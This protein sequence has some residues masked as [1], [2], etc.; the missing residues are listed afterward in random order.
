MS[1]TSA[2][3]QGLRAAGLRS[4]CW[5][6]SARLLY[7]RG[8]AGSSHAGGGPLLHRR[9]VA[10]AVAGSSHGGGS[11][12][13]GAAS[14]GDAAQ[15]ALLAEVSAIPPDRI[16]NFCIISHVDHG[17]STL[18]DRLM[19]M[20]GAVPPGGQQQMLDS[21]EVERTRGITIK[22]QT[23]SLLHREPSS[24]EAFLLNLIDTPG[25]V[26]FSYEVSR[27]IA[28][29]QGALLLVDATK[30]VQA[31]TV[32]N[33][34]LAFEQELAIT[35]VVNKIDLPHA[36]VDAVLG[37]IRDAFDLSTDGAL[38]ISAKTGVGTDALLPALLQSMPPPSARA[39]APLRL[40]LFDSWYDEYRGV[41]CLIQ[42]LGGELRLGERLVSAAS[43]KEFSVLGLELM[44]PL[45]NHGL[46][47]LGPGMVGCVALG[48]KA[49]EEACVGDTL[50][51]PSAPQPALPGFKRPRPMVFAGLYPLEEG[52]FEGLRYAMDRFLLKDGSVSVENDHSTSLGRGLRC[53]FLGMLHMEV[54]QQRLAHEHGVD[55]LVTAPT[56]PLR[57]MLRD[58]SEVPVLAAEHVPPPQHL[59]E[60]R[61]PLVD[62]TL[63]SPGEYAGPLISLC[64]AHG[65]AL[66]E[67]SYIGT[68]GRA[69]LRYRLPFA[70]IA[71]DFHDKVKGLSSG[72]ASIDY[73]EAGEQAADVVVLGLHINKQP[74]DALARIVRRNKAAGLGRQMVETMKEELDRQIYEVVIQAVVNGSTVV[75][76]ESI[77][78]ARKNVLAKCYGG[79][80]T[81]KKKL[82][83]KQ[84]AG[85]K[86]SAAAA[87]TVGDVSVPQQ[88][89]IAVLAPGK[90]K[91]GRRR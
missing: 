29:C 91:K 73:E 88:A 60:L 1:A 5:R 23:V 21:L 3:T 18:A 13:S 26:D 71:T 6:S 84:K 16:R 19:E 46:D 47:A 81:R 30:G 65:G 34:F 7:R 39:D 55:V 11:S 67:H 17:K 36:E 22:A 32:A 4:A 69:L 28:A 76:R 57:A 40:L 8:V 70:E 86:R 64:E 9:G 89:L 83:E 56:V 51:R 33:F 45:Q 35:P 63:L 62:V 41:L 87:L 59:L 54:V 44:R 31:Q 10:A 12:D 77:K 75:A 61:E 48:M 74:V 80:V 68:S 37:Q 82:L 15:A 14:A 85:K 42:V 79:D 20:T 78:A 24:G 72:F 52:G 49:I 58:G 53:G 38:C 66:L 25:H 2:A 90:R 50:S 43:G 27:S